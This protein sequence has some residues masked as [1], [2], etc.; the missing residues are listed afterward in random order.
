MLL[1]C[2]VNHVRKLNSYNSLVKVI[3]SGS[4]DSEVCLLALF[5]GTQHLTTSLLVELRVREPPISERWLTILVLKF[6]SETKCSRT[7][8]LLNIVIGNAHIGLLIQCRPYTVIVYSLNF[9]LCID[10]KFHLGDTTTNWNSIP[11]IYRRTD[12]ENFRCDK[13]REERSLNSPPMPMK[14]LRGSRN[15]FQKPF[16]RAYRAS[17]HKLYMWS[18]MLAFYLRTKTLHWKAGPKFE[19]LLLVREYAHNISWGTGRP[20]VRAS[21]GAFERLIPAHHPHLVFCA[22]LYLDALYK[23]FVRF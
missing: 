16:T 17:T 10:T 22:L 13:D 1:C 18:D 7:A 3:V 9:P 23:Y 11:R 21:C 19:G 5:R 20:R 15:I 8:L 12:E 2:N 14:D 6:L 4:L